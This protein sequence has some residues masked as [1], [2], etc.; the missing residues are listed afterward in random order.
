MPTSSSAVSAG[1]DSLL[2]LLAKDAITMWPEEALQKFT[3]FLTKAGTDETAMRKFKQAWSN[4]PI[5][6]Y[7]ACKRLCLFNVSC[8]FRRT[9]SC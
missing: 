4:I 5:A 2:Y 9:Y 3:E 6:T 7:T 1:M 8:I